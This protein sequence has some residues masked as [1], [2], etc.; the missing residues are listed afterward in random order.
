NLPKQNQPEEAARLPAVFR[1]LNEHSGWLLILES[2][3]AARFGLAVHLGLTSRNGKNRTLRH[4][5][6]FCPFDVAIPIKARCWGLSIKARSL[7]PEDLARVHYVVRVDSSL[8]CAHDAHRLA[9]LG[10]QEVDLAA[11]DAVLAGTGAIERQRTM[12]QPLVEALRFRHL[13][14]VVRIE[15]DYQVE[16]A[17]ADMAD[18]RRW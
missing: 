13:P 18:N 8:Y 16:V 14:G 15:H 9:V 11:A 3:Y 4:Q 2:S 12:D 1:W 17:V 7:D 6:Q 5:I 10:E